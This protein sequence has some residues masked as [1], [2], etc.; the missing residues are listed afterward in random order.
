MS[1]TIWYLYFFSL[2]ALTHLE[3]KGQQNYDITDIDT[4]IVTFSFYKKGE[5]YYKKIDDVDYRFAFEVNDD[6]RQEYSI[7]QLQPSSVYSLKLIDV[8]GVESTSLFTTKSRS[9]GVIKNFFNHAVEVSSIGLK[10]DGTDFNTVEREILNLIKLASKTI[11]Y[12]AYNSGMP[13]IINALIDASNRGVRVRVIADNSTSNVSL[14]SSL[15]FA[16]IKDN[17]GGLMHN[18]FIVID[19]EDEIKSMIV[20]GSMNFTSAQMKTDPN[21]IITIQDKALAQAFKIEFEE[22]WGS[23]LDRPNLS[24][25][26]FGSA[27]K[28]NTPHVF[29]VG[30]IPVQLYFSPSDQTTTNINRTLRKA[31]NNIDLNL[32]I[33][34]MEEIKNQLIDNINA[35][36]KVRGLIDDNGSS[37]A[38]IVKSLRNAGANIV[39]EPTSKIYHYKMAIIDGEGRGNPTLVTGSHNWTFSAETKNDENVLIIE[40]AEIA[41][42]YRRSMNYWW[43]QFTTDTKEPL[44]NPIKFTQQ[45]NFISLEIGENNID[46]KLFIFD[47]LG[48][49]I[50]DQKLTDLTTNIEIDNYN[51]GIYK[52]I[53][54]ENN[55]IIFERQI[56]K[57]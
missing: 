44:M 28:D 12:C 46:S 10:P 11:D 39:I 27:K 9:S 57:L 2:V 5:A 23:N 32:L 55:K 54:H 8:N 30:G 16:V 34:T 26:R 21:H 29:N 20:T 1:K 53:V 50:R 52:I 36:I 45:N 35:G 33:F 22:M 40:N 31:K 15:P 43:N 7:D 37:S 51:K 6:I 47:V 49:R 19:A 42:L 56:I 38:S 48:R 13:S 14:N 41:D 18:K 3:V 4:S 25:A 24:L 17:D